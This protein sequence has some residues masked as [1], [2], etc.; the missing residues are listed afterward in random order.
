MILIRSGLT[1]YDL[2]YFSPRIV[3]VGPKTC[4]LARNNALICSAPTTAL[5]LLTSDYAWLG[6]IWTAV[7]RS[8]L[9]TCL[10]P[11]LCSGPELGAPG[12]AEV[13]GTLGRR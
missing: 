11:D 10:L 12:E 2:L 9:P 5:I 1:D 8:C 4:S 6:L 3:F 13:A 7:V